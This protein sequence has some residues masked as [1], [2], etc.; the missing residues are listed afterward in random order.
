MKTYDVR[1][2]WDAEAG[3]WWAESDDVP[4]LVAEAETLDQLQRDLG[5][6]VPELMRLNEGWSEGS[7]SLRVLADRTEVLRLA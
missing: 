2:H 3:V 4:G 6:L 7:M 5:E 1:A